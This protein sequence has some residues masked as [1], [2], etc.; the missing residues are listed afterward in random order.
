[1]IKEWE[2]VAGN[3]LKR[4]F[5]KVQ[6]FLVP[7]SLVFFQCHTTLLNHSISTSLY[8]FTK[9]TRKTLHQ[10]FYVNGHNS[11]HAPQTHSCANT[12]CRIVRSRM[13]S[14]LRA[15]TRSAVRFSVDVSKD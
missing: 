2:E 5:E 10:P 4:K 9:K 15:P 13:I 11:P 14:E 6:N 8:D 7:F 12:L 3:D 1:M